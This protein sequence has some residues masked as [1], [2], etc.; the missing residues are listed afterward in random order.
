MTK[1]IRVKRDEITCHLYF[2]NSQEQNK[3]F[4]SKCFVSFFERLNKDKFSLP[5]KLVETQK[6]I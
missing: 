5:L 6:S 1:I 4:N 3:Q 2:T